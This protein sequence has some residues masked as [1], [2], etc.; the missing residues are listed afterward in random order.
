M[1]F[2]NAL[3][4]AQSLG[5]EDKINDLR[6]RELENKR[7]IAQS[8]AKAKMFADDLD[9]QNAA[10]SY[11]NPLIKEFA[12]TKIKEIGSYYRNN[13]DLFNN[14]DKLAQVNLMK[15]ELRDNEHIN[16]GLASDTAYK[17]YL[18][19]LQEVSKNP[20]QHDTE[21]YQDIQNQ[22]NNYLQYGNQDG[23]DAANKYGAKAFVYTK[24]KDFVDLPSTLLKAGNSIKDYDVKKGKNIGEYWTEPKADEVKAIKDSIYQQHGRQIM[25]EANKLGLTTPQQIDKWVSD[26]IAAGFDKKYSVGDPNAAFN[27]GMRM[28][29]YQLAKGKAEG[30]EITD[31]YTTW[32]DFT[33]SP[34][35]I[36]PADVLR[37]VWG[38]KPPIKVTGNNGAIADLSGNDFDYDG[39]HVNING[40]KFLT[41]TVNLPLEV[42]EEK[43]IL[44]KGSWFTDKKVTS[45]FLDK[46]EIVTKVDDKGNK[47]EYVKVKYELPVD[48][49][50]QTSKSMYEINTMPSKLVESAV[51]ETNTFPKG[52][53]VDEAG[54]VFLNGKY[55]GKL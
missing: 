31:K 30:K 45:D 46:A 1:E 52:S 9:F 12:K 15:R 48:V 39:K 55:I 35:G 38:D 24:P 23:V 47:R 5:F 51:E 50:N 16:R 34:A 4:L 17:G 53:Q 36:V 19:D 26:N 44:N 3:G 18:K 41:G 7:A 6:F 10:N 28:R 37:K 14:P 43:G 40:V 27:N 13:P 11:D 25:V 49:K 54:N 8:E 29:E 42:A 20:N 22:W 33:K 21:A 32:D 2:G